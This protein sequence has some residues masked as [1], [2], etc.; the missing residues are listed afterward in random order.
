MGMQL[1]I[2]DHQFRDPAARE[3]RIRLWWT[4][5]IIDRTC[6]SKIGLPVSIADNDVQVDRPTSGFSEGLNAADFADSEYES[7]S[8]E[9]ARIAAL[10]TE[11]LYIRRE[12]HQ[13]FSQRVQAVLKELDQWMD[14][15]PSKFHLRTKD[16]SSIQENHV[17]YLHLRFNQV[18]TPFFVSFRH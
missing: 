7:C 14:T 17:V 18:S 16:S 8:I 9:L 13:P 5:Y 4:T 15:L 3:H 11:R 6:T 10:S 12:H 1:S 2:S